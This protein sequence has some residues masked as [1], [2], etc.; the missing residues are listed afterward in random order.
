[1]TQAETNTT[2]SSGISPGATNSPS[3]S[4]DRFNSHGFEG[5]QGDG[6]ADS[7]GGGVGTV[8]G[9]GGQGNGNGAGG[10]AE[11][12]QSSSIPGIV[13]G[14]IGTFAFSSF[15]VVSCR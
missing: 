13:G 15:V 8:S 11:G 4:G 5:L 9:A 6:R 3:F 14:V 7:P 12:S 10:P 1:L 2:P